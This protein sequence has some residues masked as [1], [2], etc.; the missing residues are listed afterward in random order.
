MEEQ[1]RWN[2][3]WFVSFADILI[4]CS[5][6]PAWMHMLNYQAWNPNLIGAIVTPVRG[7][8]QEEGGIVLIKRV[9]TDAQTPAPAAFYA[10]TIRLVAPR[11]IVW[12]AYPEEGDAFRDLIDF[13]LCE[14]ASGVQFTIS[15][16]AQTESTGNMLSTQRNDRETNLRQLAVSFKVHCE[17]SH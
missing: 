17:G 11:H 16:Y 15:Y 7:N 8:P 10:E 2:R 12:F 1:R 3:T 6:Q 9:S 5:L 13:A 4:D 14:V